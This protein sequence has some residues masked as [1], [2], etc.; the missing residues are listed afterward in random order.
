MK[1]I[2]SRKTALGMLAAVLVAVP[3]LASA[4]DGPLKGMIVSHDGSTIV[5]RS[6]G[7]DTPV[8]LSESTKIRGIEG[9]LGVRGEDHPPSDLIRGLAVEVKTAGGGDALTATEVTFKKS[10]L[11]TAKQIAAG[12][13]STEAQVQENT[14]RIDNVAELKALDRTNVLFAT[15][16]ATISAKG[17]Q[18]LQA[19]ATKA[20]GITGYRL[21]VVGRA[22][23]T[24]NAAANQRLSERRAAAVRDYLLKSCGVMPGRILA[25][26]S[27]GSSEI[28]QDPNPPKTDAEARRVTVTIAVSKSSRV[29]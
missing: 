13:A 9:A 16:S 20:K 28:A 8:V 3:G 7:K 17:K 2:I 14:D 25:T 11:K 1:S 12:I 24:G 19:I 6:G 22:D 26:E 27:L 18:D 4:Q 23:K 15:G 29:Q 5:V 10:D 21:A